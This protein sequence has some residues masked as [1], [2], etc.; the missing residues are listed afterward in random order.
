MQNLAAAVAL[1]VERTVQVPAVVVALGRAAQTPTLRLVADPDL[2]VAGQHQVLRV[3]LARSEVL[4]RGLASRQLV[5]NHL[6]AHNR[7]VL[8]AAQR[9]RV[10]HCLLARM[11]QLLIES[12]GRGFLLKGLAHSEPDPVLDKEV[13]ELL[14]LEDVLGLYF[15]D[16]G[17]DWRFE[18][19]PGLLRSDMLFN[20]LWADVPLLNYATMP[21]LEQIEDAQ[22]GAEQIGDSVVPSLLHPEL[23]GVLALV[24][25]VSSCRLG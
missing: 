1:V 14:L 24:E 20:V 25:V 3:L 7:T 15:R 8:M 9:R 23:L 22:I 19:R 12:A 11:Q 10:A 5:K 6:L 4:E 17:P 16:V 21:A 13:Y 2:A 18:G